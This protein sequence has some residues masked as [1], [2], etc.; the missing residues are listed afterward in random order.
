MKRHEL[1]ILRTV[2]IE[3]GKRLQIDPSRSLQVVENRY[4]HEGISFLSI[5]LPAMHDDFIEAVSAGRWLGS[6]LFGVKKG[7]PV[8]MREFLQLVFNFGAAGCHLKEGQTAIEAVVVIRQCLLL[9]KKQKA[10]PSESRKRKAVESFFE[11]ERELRYRRNEI[12]N[13][14]SDD[15]DRINMILFGGLYSG[16]EDDI[17][18]GA[19]MFKHGPGSVAEAVY[20]V[21]KYAV[22]RSTWT[23][24]LDKALPYDEVCFTNSRHW[25]SLVDSQL[26]LSPGAELA[27]RVI[28]VPKTQKTPRIIAAD[29]TVN[30]FVQQGVHSS[31][32]KGVKRND[33]LRSSIDW[34]NQE[35]QKILA[36]LGSVDGSLATLD[37]SE[38]SD[39]VH[40]SLVA[41]M[42]KH[43][44]LLRDVVFACR[45]TRADFSGRSIF[46][47]KFAPM[48]SALCFPFETMVFTIIVVRAVLRAWGQPVTRRNVINALRNVSLYGDD[49]IVPTET[50]ILVMHDLESFGLKVNYRKSFWT[51]E[52]RESCGGDYFR[53]VDVTPVY[54]RYNLLDEND[55]R[56]L[57]AT[58]SSQNQFFDKCWFEVADY[59]TRLHK[60]LNKVST[61]R[62]ENYRGFMFKGFSDRGFYHDEG[63]QC[64]V[65]TAAEFSLR[66]RKHSNP[67]GWDQLMDWMISKEKSQDP[68]SGSLP[69]ERRPDIHHIR[70][71]PTPAY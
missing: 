64:S 58:I 54:L 9:F 16:V 27:M 44:R 24:R 51:G 37:L 53:G 21:R 45:T 69:L 39:R 3:G 18:V 14:W 46:L 8:F 71:I 67:D 52:F 32:L 59:L 13:A 26:P 50:A 6:R 66:V 62:R 5:S 15:H 63:L 70:F 34:T 47:E 17:R 35:R 49:I 55:P 29:Q 60:K 23:H 1:D 68:I 2:F 20:G 57:A 30:Q 33:I 7:S 12:R 25:A 40:V 19:Y 56:S 28:L 10:L 41:R 42:L 38:A 36:H 31:L 65:F 4:K 61:T 48:G 22:A 11:T 43:H